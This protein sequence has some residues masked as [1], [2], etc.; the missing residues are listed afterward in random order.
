MAERSDQGGQGGERDPDATLDSISAGVVRTAPAPSSQ[1]PVEH[2][3]RYEFLA[4]LGQGG[5]GTVYKARDRRLGRLV[6]LKF[7]RG[8]DARMTRRFMQEARAQSRIDHPGV[9]KVYEVG[10][11][12]GKAYIAMQL[13]DGLSLQLAADSMSTTDKVRVIKDAAEAMHAAHEL[14]VIHRDLKPA[15]IMVQRVLDANGRAA[16]RPVVMD[17][18]L[19]REAGE[20]QALTESGAVMGTPAYMSPEQARGEVRILDRRTDVYSLGA[21]LYDLLA[22]QPPFGDDATIDAIMRII[23]D[24]APRIRKKQPSIPEALDDIIHKCLRKEPGERYA[25]AQALADDLARFLSGQHTSTAKP[26][27]LARLRAGARR[28]KQ[29]LALGAALATVLLTLAGYGIRHHNQTLRAERQAWQ[30]RTLAQQVAQAAQ[31]QE[32]L[33]RVTYLMPPHDIGRERSLLRA[34]LAARQRALRSQGPV[35]AGLDHYLLGRGHLALKEWEAALAELRRAEQLEFRDAELDLALGRLLGALYRQSLD[36][37]GKSSDPSRL[38]TRRK[39]LAQQL[40]DPAVR[41]LRALREGHSD[42]PEYVQALIALYQRRYEEACTRAEQART[43]RPWMYELDQLAADAHRQRGQEL[44]QSSSPA[45]RSEYEQA[46]S[47]YQRA[48]E[49][50]R[51][52][53]ALPLAEALTWGAVM[54]LDRSAGTSPEDATTRGLQACERA[55]ALDPDAAGLFTTRAW[56]HLGLADWLRR[57]GREPSLHL[58]QA[59][60][61]AERALSRRSDDLLAR[62]LLTDALWQSALWEDSQGR[63]SERALLTVIESAERGQQLDAAHLPLRLLAGR[64]YQA[65]GTWLADRGQPA[66]EVFEKALSHLEKA[67]EIEPGQAEALALSLRSYLRLAQIALSRGNDPEPYLSKA[68]ELNAAEL[69]INPTAWTLHYARAGAEI[70]RAQHQIQSGAGASA[71][72]AGLADIAEALRYNPSSAESCWYRADLYALRAWEASLQGKDPSAAIEQGL[73]AAGRAGALSKGS[74]REARE[75]WHLAL[76]LLRARALLSVR[77][78]ADAVLTEGIA[79]AQDLLTPPPSHPQ[80]YRILAELY[81]AQAESQLQ[82][83][84]PARSALA[85]GQLALEQALRLNPRQADSL[86]AQGRLQLVAAKAERDPAARRQLAAQS[87]RSFEQALKENRLLHRE[88]DPLLAEA[89]RL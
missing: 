78:A 63:L 60:A 24:E 54:R 83:G 19:A 15:N 58:S 88:Y 67:L 22:G 62:E 68:A 49:T 12:S 2:W 51:S 74:S 17:F 9:C 80:P 87:V 25:T 13:I 46:V 39:E 35:D 42:P 65:R 48:A 73:L 1:W 8:G 61:A 66:Q 76:H 41:H 75:G 23:R 3:D 38:E 32:L 43:Q 89:R 33:A 30:Q 5:M 37:A 21:A 86:A 72:D 84:K 31:E 71:I 16:Y 27:R 55:L 14:G 7:I 11:A 45:A 18:G 4:L 6:A 53:P 81:A 28:Q 50:A 79:R 69:R 44:A 26:G 57:T 52:D 36:E 47:L 70:L 40:L 29:R 20:G 77:S 85:A 59:Q 34:R 10:E 82:R 56:L 64:S